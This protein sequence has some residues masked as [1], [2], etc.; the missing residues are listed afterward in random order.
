MD[1]AWVEQVTFSMTGYW[2]ALFRLGTA[3]TVPPGAIEG[4]PPDVVDQVASQ[5]AG[6]TSETMKGK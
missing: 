2:T 1:E 4:F 6:D 5:L 3:Y